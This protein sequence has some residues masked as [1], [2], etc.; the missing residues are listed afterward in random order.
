MCR[1]LLVKS[2]TEFPISKHLKKFSYVAENS[3]EYQGHGWGCVYL[4]NGNWK[5]YK[6][7]NPIWADNLDQFGKTAYLLAHARSAFR[8][9]GIA[10]ENN[11]PF[12]SGNTFFIFNGELHG[13]K[14]K[15]EG[16]IGAEKLFNYILRFF[17]K[18]K[19]DGFQKSLEIIEKRTNYIKAMNII[20][21]DEEQI[22]FTSVHNED[23]DYFTLFKKESTNDLII[24]SEPFTNGTDWEKIP[25]HS[26]RIL[27]K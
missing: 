18:N 5:T 27:D 24:C 8:D 9:E 21:I 20:M 10:I 7:I 13:V 19:K 22:Y 2:K 4:R 6:N 25:N 14:I 11:M 1:L 12:Q 23:H 3:R 17:Q 15:E 26:K 16:R